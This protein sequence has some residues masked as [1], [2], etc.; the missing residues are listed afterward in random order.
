MS[1]KDPNQDPTKL[2]Q[3]YDDQDGVGEGDD[4]EVTAKAPSHL[5]VGK[6][7][8]GQPSGG[9]SNEGLSGNVGAGG[10]LWESDDGSGNKD[11]TKEREREEAGGVGSGSVARGDDSDK[12]KKLMLGQ[13]PN[14]MFVAQNTPFGGV[15]GPGP[16]LTVNSGAVPPGLQ[17]SFDPL[18][19]VWSSVPQGTGM[20]LQPGQQY[21]GAGGVGMLNPFQ[22]QPVASL[23]G[24]LVDSQ[25]LQQV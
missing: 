5:S 9:G 6:V 15:S 18:S 23:Q 2:K 14:F 4:D 19:G 13:N 24:M 16:W 21:S 25:Q 20:L 10:I 17:W 22:V 8:T 3:Q 1:D 7:E 12:V 11:K